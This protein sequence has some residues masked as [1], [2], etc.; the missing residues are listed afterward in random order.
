[1][2][3]LLMVEGM[4]FEII[5]ANM[6]HL[7]ITSKETCKCDFLCLLNYWHVTAAYRLI[8]IENSKL[9]LKFTIHIENSL[10]KLSYFIL[11]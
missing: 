2:S 11:K 4:I 8:K 3:N 9:N 1:M 7:K 5:I 6:N 10:Y